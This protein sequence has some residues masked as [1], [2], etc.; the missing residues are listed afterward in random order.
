MSFF[1]PKEK[2]L[3]FETQEDLPKFHFDVNGFLMFDDPSL[4]GCH[5]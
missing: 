1:K 5:L 3:D 4:G 2:E